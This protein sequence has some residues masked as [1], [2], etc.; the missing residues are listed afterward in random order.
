VRFFAAT[1]NASLA[2]VERRACVSY[3]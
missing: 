1:I 3:R 2:L